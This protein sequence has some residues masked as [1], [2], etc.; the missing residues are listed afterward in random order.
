[1]SGNNTI[2]SLSKASIAAIAGAAHAAN[3]A[4]CRSLGDESQKAWDEAPDWQRDSA[5]QGVEFHLANPDAT[6]AA[7]HE[8]WL[9][10]KEADGWKFGEK[11]DEKAKTHPCFVPFDH[12][13]AEQQFKDALFRTTVHAMAPHLAELEAANAKLEAAA[14]KA[15]NAPKVKSSEAKG[16][17]VGLL[18]KDAQN[19]PLEQLL[20]D[21][22][23]AKTVELAFSDGKGEVTGLPAGVYRYRPAGHA[24]V[25]LAEGDRRRAL[26]AAAGGQEWVRRG[27]AVI[28]A[29]GVPRRTAARAAP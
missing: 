9:K 6:D 10:A 4:Y 16:R 25:R 1:M 28:V 5:V 15:K 8:N 14:A 13:P 7:S 2:T 29:A 27:A 23:E 26:A 21:I 20:E 17:K 3:A 24:L 18:A 12:L 11:K 22:R 19:P